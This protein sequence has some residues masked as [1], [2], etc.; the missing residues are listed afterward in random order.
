MEMSGKNELRWT[1]ELARVGAGRVQT[2]ETWL[3]GRFGEDCVKK[4]LNIELDASELDSKLCSYLDTIELD[5]NS[6]F[7]RLSADNFGSP[8]W[9]VMKYRCQLANESESFYRCRVVLDPSLSQRSRISVQDQLLITVI[10]PS[11]RAPEAPDVVEIR[12]N[13]VPRQAF[14]ADM[15]ATCRKRH[16]KCMGGFS[17]ISVLREAEP[18]PQSC[19]KCALT[20]QLR[21]GADIGAGLENLRDL[22]KDDVE[23]VKSLGKGGQGTVEKILWRRGVFAKK[24]FN[25][26]K[27]FVKEVEIAT[28]VSHPNIVHCFGTATGDVNLGPSLFMEFLEEDLETRLQEPIQESCP[29]SHKD[30]LDILRQV[31]DAMK[32]LHEKD[33]IHGDLKPGNIFLSRLTMPHTESG[34]FYLVKVA[35][36]GCAQRIPSEGFADPKSNTPEKIL[37]NP[38]IGTTEYAAPEVLRI[39]SLKDKTPPEHPKMIDV[40]SFGVVA[41]QVLMGV[42]CKELYKNYGSSVKLRNEGIMQGKVRPDSDFYGT[43]NCDRKSLLALVKR[44][45]RK[46]LLALV[47]RCWDPIPEKRP[48]FSD[49]YDELISIEH[50]GN[51]M[52]PCNGGVLA[53][54][55]KATIIMCCIYVFYRIC[56]SAKPGQT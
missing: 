10:Q 47:K 33:F 51:A 20:E 29:F 5:E 41:Y 17:P 46:S 43:L 21:G 4:L 39:R 24:S 45:E 37:F 11:S 14:L 49:I 30:I 3:D 42:P 18:Y 55:L 31:A 22:E 34:K 48:P 38:C 19:T 35:D 7:L 56:V 26:E 12:S 36:F 53:K 15:N 6:Q 54:L 1:I 27:D 2:R 28:K 44:C 16:G 50:G 52:F 25:F 8:S 23:T 40:Y 32:Q 13:V 9:K